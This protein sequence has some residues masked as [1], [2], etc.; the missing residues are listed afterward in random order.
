MSAPIMDD[1]TLR[2]V[3]PR[4]AEH[5]LDSVHLI[6]LPACEEARLKGP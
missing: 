5:R 1:R 6:P 3:G 2:D 4:I